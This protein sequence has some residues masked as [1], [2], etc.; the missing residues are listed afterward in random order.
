MRRVPL[1]ILTLI[2][3][4]TSQPSSEQPSDSSADSL[5]K[6]ELILDVSLA[7]CA[8]AQS[9]QPVRGERRR[10]SSSLRDAPWGTTAI[11]KLSLRDI[12][13]CVFLSL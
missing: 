11:S 7:W 4:P 2:V 9:R 12:D 10:K 5:L 13:G 3:L 1:R 6:A 8:M